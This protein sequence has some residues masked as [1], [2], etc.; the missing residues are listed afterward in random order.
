MKPAGYEACYAEIMAARLPAPKVYQPFT[1][2]FD[3]DALMCIRDHFGVD[4]Y[5]LCLEDATATLEQ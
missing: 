3:T 2:Y 4:L 1:Q 5:L